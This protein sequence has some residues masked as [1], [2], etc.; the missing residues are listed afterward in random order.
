MVIVDEFHHAA[1]ST[2]RALL[3]H[4][5]PKVLLG[6]T[7]T[8]ERADGQSVTEWFD[9][10]FAAEL[11][12]W[13]AIDGACSCPS[14]TSGST[15]RSTFAPDVAARAATYTSEL[16]NLY[17]GNDARGWPRCWRR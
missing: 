14:S 10:R 9:G 6:L 16:D 2:Y 1:A 15:T 8:P 7:A 4:L 13:D 3:D 12:L 11:R 5:Q 17:T